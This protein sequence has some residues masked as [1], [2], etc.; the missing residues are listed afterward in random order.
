VVKEI[1]ETLLVSFTPQLRTLG[2]GVVLDLLQ[3][4]MA[5]I[6]E[7][8]ARILL[9]HDTTAT[10]LPPELIESLLA[11]PYE[12]MRGISV[13]IFGQ[14]PDETLLQRYELLLAMATH[15]LPDMRHA[16]RP[17]IR[18]LGMEH[19]EFTTELAT[20]LINVLLRK[21]RNEGVHSRPLAKVA[22]GVL[23]GVRASDR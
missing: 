16:I 22:D 21:E 11:S 23:W 17:V 12:S 6:Q 20:E 8:G 13:I 5:E 2:M 18:R 1:A 9:N 7:L 10:D 19:P 4:P 14:L 15:E 3:H